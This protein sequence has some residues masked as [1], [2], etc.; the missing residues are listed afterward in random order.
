M[1]IIAII[2]GVA[3]VILFL[4]KLITAPQDLMN[5]WIIILL[6]S[7]IGQVLLIEMMLMFGNIAVIYTHMGPRG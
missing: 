7:L 5:K 2:I 3:T 1:N 4:V 6:A